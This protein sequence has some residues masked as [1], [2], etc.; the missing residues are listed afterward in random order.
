VTV[1]AAIIASGSR[2]CRAFISVLRLWLVFFSR[3][4]VKCLGLGRYCS[5]TAQGGGGGDRCVPVRTALGKLATC[6]LDIGGVHDD[7]AAHIGVRCCLHGIAIPPVRHS[8]P[9]AA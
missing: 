5:C 4:A 2:M 7:D 8:D 9:A 3:P 1:T 6:A